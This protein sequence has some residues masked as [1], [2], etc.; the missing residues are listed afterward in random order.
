LGGKQ[1]DKSR[2]QA[3][4]YCYREAETQLLMFSIEHNNWFIAQDVVVGKDGSA[5]DRCP[6]VFHLILQSGEPEP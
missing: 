2:T 6:V 1:Q 5:S 3:Y 4:S